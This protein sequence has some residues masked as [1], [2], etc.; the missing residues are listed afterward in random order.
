MPILMPSRHARKTSP[1]AADTAMDTTTRQMDELRFLVVEDHGFQRWATRKMLEGLGASH[2]FEAEDGRAA[3]EVFR[4]LNEPIDIIVSDLDMPGMD[5][6]EFIRHLGAVGLPASL[7]IASALNPALVASVETMATAYGINLLGALGKPVTPE[8]LALAI[9]RHSRP[10]Q[11]APALAALAFAPE[12][13]LEGLRKNEFEPFFQPKIE[14][15]SGRI[16]GAEA[17]ARWQHPVNGV[18]SPIAFIRP[19]EESGHIDSL[20]LVMLKMAANSCR[21][22]RDAGLDA[23]VSVNLSL[24]S[25]TDVTLADRITDLVL[26]QQ[27]DPQHVI[28]EVTESAAASHVGSALEN[29][30]R[31]RMKGFGLSIDDFGTGYSSMQQ[32]SR[33]AFSELKIDQ[34]FVRNASRQESSKVILESSLDMARR[35]SIVAVA[36]GVET[37]PEWE[38]LRDLHC[39]LAQGYF[40]AR[41]MDA[42]AFYGWVKNWKSMQL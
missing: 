35:L 6:M 29:L 12:E 34:T 4:N 30:S 24:K 27:I 36:E 18:V 9:G 13:I 31:L 41:P 10:K 5:G 8:K 19:L 40:V 33:I 11:K 25:L 15:A 28:L 38:L 7:I 42:G 21:I 14:L 17:L 16:R 3:L 20:T 2:I 22:W 32:L 1:P 26:A 37:Q 23:S 39:D